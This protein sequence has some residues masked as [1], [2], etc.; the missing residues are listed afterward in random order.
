MA[1]VARAGR[2]RGRITCQKICQELAPSITAASSSSRGIC[3]KNWRS[4]K[5]AKAPPPNQEGRIRGHQVSIR[6]VPKRA[7]GTLLN[8]RNLGIRTTSSGSTRVASRTMKKKSRPHQRKRA[9]P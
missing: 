7:R 5:T 4:R 6:V 8:I 2:A 3:M 1:T 9:K